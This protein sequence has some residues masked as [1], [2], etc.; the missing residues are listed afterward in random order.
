MSQA[1]EKVTAWKEQAQSLTGYIPNHDP[2]LM[3][4]M[5]ALESL[6]LQLAVMAKLQSPVLKHKHWEAI[7][8]GECT[9]ILTHA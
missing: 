2:V 1:Q 5:G 9:H 4:T 7:S 3:Q 6:G 8:G